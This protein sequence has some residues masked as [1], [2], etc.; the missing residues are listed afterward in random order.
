[1]G[2][3]GYLGYTWDTWD[4]TNGA[5]GQRTQYAENTKYH[6]QHNIPRDRPPTT[7]DRQLFYSIPASATN[8]AAGRRPIAF[9]GL[10]DLTHVLD[11]DLIVIRT[12]SDPLVT[13]TKRRPANTYCRIQYLCHKFPYMVTRFELR[14]R[15]SASSTTQ[16]ATKPLWY[17]GPTI[18]D[19]GDW[20]ER[21]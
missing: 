2:Y 19:R 20:L 13:V 3:L 5:S 18:N 9:C 7:S 1:M 10:P 6:G 12:R 11:C 15:D 8:P 17:A 14:R 21:S 4:T 16:R